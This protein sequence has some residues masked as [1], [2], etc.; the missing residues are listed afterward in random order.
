MQ[1][2]AAGR[3]GG[4]QLCF[5]VGVRGCGRHALVEDFRLCCVSFVGCSRSIPRVPHVAEHTV[6]ATVWLQD[7]G[8]LLLVPPRYPSAR[9]GERES[10]ELKSFSHKSGCHPSL[11]EHA[12][13]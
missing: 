9:H 3:A 11:H 10:S 4:S 6:P 13:A 5:V 7:L 12:V 8:A 1:R 2:A